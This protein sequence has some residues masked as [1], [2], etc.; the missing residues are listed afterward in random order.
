M[1]VLDAGCGPGDVA[2]LAAGMVG[3]RGDVVGVDNSPTALETAR[4]RV[5]RAGLTN[6]SFVEGDLR[7]IEIEDEFDAP[8]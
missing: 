2:L 7:S 3:P 5:A 1:R 4:V 6:V 8:F